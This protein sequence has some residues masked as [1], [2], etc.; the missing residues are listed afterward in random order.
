PPLRAGFD[1]TC[2][3]SRHGAG[4]GNLRPDQCPELRPKD[5]RRRSGYGSEVAGGNPGLFGRKGGTCS[6][7]VICMLGTVARAS[8]MASAWTCPEE[9]L[10][11][12]WAQ[13]VLEN[14]P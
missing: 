2:H 1:D 10:S 4:D 9:G 12:C 3:R 11:P 6:R 13:M 5:C 14:Q 8:S 7:C